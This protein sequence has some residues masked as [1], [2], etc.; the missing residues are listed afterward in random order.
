MDAPTV[1]DPG[2]ADFD[3]GDVGVANSLAEG[4]QRPESEGLK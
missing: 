1:D 4:R 2:S 3:A